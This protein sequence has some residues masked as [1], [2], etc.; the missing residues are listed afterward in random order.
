LHALGHDFRDMRGVQQ[1]RTML[2]KKALKVALIASKS[3][4]RHGRR[5]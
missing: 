1:K 4:M 2:S 3:S 5:Q